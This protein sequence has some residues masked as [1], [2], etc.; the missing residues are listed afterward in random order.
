[1]NSFLS[2]LTNFQIFLTLLILG[3]ISFFPTFFNSFVADD[4]TYILNNP[5]IKN[6]NL[7]S[8]FTGSSYYVGDV[9]NLSGIYYKPVFTLIT[10]LLFQFSF[11]QAF[12]FHVTQLILHIIISFLLFILFAKFFSKQISLVLSIV[13]LIHP[14]NVETVVYAAN[15]QDLLFP[16][17]GLIA[18]LASFSDKISLKRGIFLSFFLLE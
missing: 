15:L 12:I 10:S 6:F 7:I 13:F 8:F 9:V 11:G 1:M 4:N 3:T 5:L 14:G 2:K 17:F 16:F 18:I